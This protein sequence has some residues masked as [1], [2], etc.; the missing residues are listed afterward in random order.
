MNYPIRPAIYLNINPAA[1][2]IPDNKKRT[3]AEPS[4]EK[5]VKK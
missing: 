3:I 1:R 2:L 4:H 5:T